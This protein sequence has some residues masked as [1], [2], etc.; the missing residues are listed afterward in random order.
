MSI[1]FGTFTPSN[2]LAPAQPLTIYNL[3]AY[4]AYIRFI[5]NSPYQLSVNLDS[6]I[7]TIPEFYIQDIPKSQNVRTIIVTPTANISTVSHAQSNSLTIEAYYAFEVAA[8]VSQAIPQQAVDATA[9]GKPIFSATVGF[10]STVGSIQTL[11]VFNP[12]NSGVNM[13]FHSA[14]A[15][16]NDSS[17]PA[18]NLLVVNGG[19]LNLPTAVSAVSHNAQGVPPVSAA[20]CTADDSNTGHGG[21]AIE[22]MDMQQF[23]TQDV[24]DFP[25]NVTL[26]PGN[27]LRIAISSSTTGHVVRFTMKWSEDIAVPPQGGLVTGIVMSSI[28]NTG[29]AAPTPVVTASP[30]SENTATLINNDGTETLGS[31]TRTPAIKFA[32][33]ASAAVSVLASDGT[34]TVNLAS[35]LNTK[36]IGLFV[37][38]TKVGHI[39]NGGIHLEAGAFQFDGSAS[40]LTTGLF[41]MLAGSI[42]RIT[43]GVVSTNNAGATVTHGLGALPDVV[44][45]TVEN[46]STSEVVSWNGLTSTQFTAWT[47]GATLRNV[48]WLAM[49]A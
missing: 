22:V 15:F 49:K 21:T 39:D 25:D 6:T 41:K 9:S 31:N 1:N 40:T 4:Y 14:R 45:L 28:V 32:D 23:V 20:H 8:P 3:D 16:T 5:N 10:G 42:T 37:G 7:V 27:N 44:L 33:P 29:N 17:I 26:A 38:A 11:N 34:G 12:A 46:A 35:L 19:D 18:A 47:N 24:L 48:H 30:L 13:T 36:Q 43:A 2:F